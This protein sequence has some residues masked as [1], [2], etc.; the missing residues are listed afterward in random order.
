LTGLANQ[1]YFQKRLREETDRARRYQRS[2]A[3]ILLDMDD[4]KGINDSYGHQAGDAV[5]KRMGQVLRR[6]IRAIDIVA[7]YGGDEF[8]VIMPE[9]DAGTCERFM[10]RLQSKIES[11]RFSA[12]IIGK[13]F[14]CT[15]SLGGAVFPEHASEPDQ[16]VF[17][18]DM[19]LLRAKES[20]RNSYLLYERTPQPG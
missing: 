13:E 12:E 3:L 2:M 1:R 11:S 14:T 20:G 15:I 16:L 9:A 7:R 10:N 4:L 8:C 18:A 5:I 17:A 6:S 19:A